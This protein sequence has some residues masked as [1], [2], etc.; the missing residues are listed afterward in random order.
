MTYTFDSEIVSDLHKDAYGFR[1]RGDW[2]NMWEQS[3]DAERQAIWDR[4]LKD[5]NAEVEAE[6]AAQQRAIESFELRV[7]VVASM[8]AGDRETALRWIMDADAA[9]GDWDHLCYINGLPY[10]YFKQAVA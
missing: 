5:L 10:G 3:T 1:P 8:G 9:D 2:W 6:R 4:L 7:Q